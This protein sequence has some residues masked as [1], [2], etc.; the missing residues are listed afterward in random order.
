M[1]ILGTGTEIIE[2][3]RISRMIETHGEQFLERVYTSDEIAY[4]LA[5][6]SSTQHFAK[7]WA[8]KEATVK[9]MRCRNQGVRWTDIEISSPAGEGPTILLH[10]AAAEWAQQVGIE[11]LHVALGACRTHATAYILATDELE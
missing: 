2:C 6:G 9:A 11:K 7:R 10:G 5:G 3:V 8:A 1:A 4:C